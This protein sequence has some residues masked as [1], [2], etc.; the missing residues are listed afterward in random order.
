MRTGKN[1]HHKET[2]ALNLEKDDKQ[3]PAS[4]FNKDQRKDA[5]KGQQQQGQDRAHQKGNQQDGQ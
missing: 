4:Q 3:F 2:K 1:K 5:Q